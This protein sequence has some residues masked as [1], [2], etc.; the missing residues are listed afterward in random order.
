MTPSGALDGRAFMGS[1][2]DSSVEDQY[3]QLVISIVQVNAMD[4]RLKRLYK[5]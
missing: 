1:G 4:K 3:L 2:A 5:L